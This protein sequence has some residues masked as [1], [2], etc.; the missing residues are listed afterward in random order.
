MWFQFPPDGDEFDLEGE[1]ATPSGK[2]TKKTPKNKKKAAAAPKDT[3]VTG[4]A[5]T[6]TGEEKVAPLKIKLNKKKK[7]KKTSSVSIQ[8][9]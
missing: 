1:D 6:P 2:K 5:G 3:P 4:D 7:K 8:F 9:T